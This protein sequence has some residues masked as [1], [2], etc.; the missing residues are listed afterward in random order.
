M[1]R[2]A[3]AGASDVARAGV[4]SIV[5]SIDGFDLVGRASG[6]DELADLV[7][8]ATP[9][10]VLVDTGPSDIDEVSRWFSALGDPLHA[11]GVVLLSDEPADEAFS[12]HRA[13]ASLPRRAGRDEIEASI[14]AVAVGLVVLHPDALDQP[15]P[16]RASVDG[17]VLTPREIEVLGM[18]AAGL[19]NKAIARK[20]GVSA[21]T[22]KFHVGSIMTKL[23]AS[24]RTE[25][26]TDGIRRGL[27]FL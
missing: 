14:R 5:S 11:P 7:R 13:W 1:T 27:I 6:P 18:L 23:H 16:V 12:H 8:S 22:V 21:H 19:P 26:V 17:G 24:S 9:D 20:L 3:I 4:A 2:I 15:A 25:A 10:V